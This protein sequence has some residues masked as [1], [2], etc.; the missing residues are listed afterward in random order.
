MRSPLA[1]SSIACSTSTNADSTRIAT[2]GKRTRISRAAASP[3]VV[4]GRGHPDVDHG[5]V[6]PGLLDQV[7]QVWA[8]VGKPDHVETVPV[9]EARKSLAQQH[10]IVRDHHRRCNA[11]LASN[12]IKSNISPQNRVV[13]PYARGVDG[14]PRG[15]L[16]AVHTADQHG[17]RRH[18]A[19]GLPAARVR[20]TSS[21]GP[22]ARSRPQ[23]PGTAPAG[24]RGGPARVRPHP[25]P[26]AAGTVDAAPRSR[27]RCARR[28]SRRRSPASPPRPPG[29]PRS[30]PTSRRT[31]TTTPTPHRRR[32]AAPCR[33]NINAGVDHGR[34]AADRSAAEQFDDFT[35]ASG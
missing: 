25:R 4:C 21:P 10:V 26:G 9:E 15:D 22:S 13:T 12:A 19:V 16:R 1:S 11:A 3:S 31:S 27:S 20:L 28:S 17:V 18:P 6:R 23:H 7:Q 5:Q 30:T 33:A 34:P 2:D 29:S 35:D 14:S 24:R 8:V 32:G